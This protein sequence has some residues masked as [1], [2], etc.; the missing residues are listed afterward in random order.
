MEAI[1]ITQTVS[2]S[3]VSAKIGKTLGKYWMSKKTRKGRSTGWYVEA[4]DRK[5]VHALTINYRVHTPAEVA[6]VCFNSGG[7]M[8]KVDQVNVMLPKVIDALVAAGYTVSNVNGSTFYVS[9]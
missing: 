9:K 7:Y 8:H 4:V 5:G 3:A 6:R 1:E 2:A